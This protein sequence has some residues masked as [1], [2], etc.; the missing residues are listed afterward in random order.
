MGEVFSATVVTPRG[1]VREQAGSLWSTS[2]RRQLGCCQ[3]ES[4]DLKQLCDP[5]L[6]SLSEECPLPDQGSE[7]L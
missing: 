7:P 1:K 6:L 4:P 3:G 5:L 2:W